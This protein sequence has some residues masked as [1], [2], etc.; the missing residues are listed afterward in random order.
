MVDILKII[1]IV[2]YVILAIL[3]IVYFFIASRGKVC[4]KNKAEDIRCYTD[5]K[6]NG[7]VFPSKNLT[8][9]LSNPNCK[10]D[11]FQ[12][13]LNEK[14][15]NLEGTAK[16][17]CAACIVTS[18]IEAYKCSEKFADEVQKKY[19]TAFNLLSADVVGSDECS[20]VAKMFC[21]YAKGVTWEVKDGE[22]EIID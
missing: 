7:D 19:L 6:C 16:D 13:D 8:E 5:W 17:Q 15:K 4:I 11:T 3:T 14:C 2:L 9:K 12:K 22:C 20:P 18:R 10:H 1:P 21:D